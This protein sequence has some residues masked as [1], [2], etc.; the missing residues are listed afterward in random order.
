MRS[1]LHR[2]RGVVRRHRR[3]R[4]TARLVVI[5]L[6]GAAAALLLLGATSPTRGDV[7]PGVVELQARF[8]LGDGRTE[9]RLPPFGLVS[10]PTHGAPVTLAARVDRIDVEEVQRL[11]AQPG[12]PERLEAEVRDDLDPLVRKFALKTLG[13]SLVAGALAGALVPGRHWLS[14]AAGAAGGLVVTSALFGLAW[15]R[16]DPN[17]FADRPRFEGPLER[18]PALIETAQRYITGFEDVRD[19]VEALSAQLT[20]LY[21]NATAEEFAI[22]PGSIRV[23]HVSDI[24]LNPVGLEIT[25]DLAER[26][27]VDAIVDTGDFTTFGLAPEARF[28]E[29]LAGMPAPYYLIP[30]NHDSTPI[31]QAL[32]AGGNVVLVD[33]TEFSVGSVDFLGVG[34]PVF[35]ATNEISDETYDEAIAT[36]AAANANLVDQLEPDVLAVHDPR[37]ADDAI[38]E[39][40][41]VIAGH[42]HET[43]FT[44]EGGT[45]VLT[46]GSTGATGLG[47]FAVD[48]AQPYE[49]EILRFQQGRLVAV[50][51][52]A[53]R[54][55]GEFRVERRLILEDEDD[56]EAD[57]G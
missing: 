45:F 54:T 52:V 55:S 10:A 31:R 14:A 24:H 26:F 48:T 6:V 8:R 3:L 44:D 37:Q 50:D 5:G 41:L 21:A 29:L 38:G 17:A 51:T 1:L 7:G 35:T 13:L 43:T 22:G 56:A 47:A 49:A 46:V 19:R 42:T 36:Q 30:G 27:A 39:V 11:V 23:L 18:A 40:P 4:A 53:L 16:F 57:S 34:H 28:G 15:L 12:V 20:D 2:L 9:L 25:R 32:A 33:G